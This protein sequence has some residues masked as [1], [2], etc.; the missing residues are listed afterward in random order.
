MSE[1]AMGPDGDVTQSVQ[2]DV[3]RYSVTRNAQ[4]KM[5]LDDGGACE[6]KR[7]VFRELADYCFDD[8][9]LTS[10]DDQKYVLLRVR[11]IANSGFL[12]KLCKR[13]E[14]S[15][16][17]LDHVALEVTAKTEE[18]YPFSRVI[19]TLE[20]QTILIEH[21][22]KAF[23]KSSTAAR[24]LESIARGFVG[25]PNYFIS[26]EEITETA[27]FWETVHGAERI[28]SVTFDL[29]SPN[30]LGSGYRTTEFLKMVNDAANNDSLK[31]ELRNGDGDLVIDRREFGD[32]VDYV[33]DGCGKWK[34]DVTLDGRNQ[35]VSSDKFVR[36]A[37]L[38]VPDEPSLDDERIMRRI[39]KL[40]RKR[41]GNNDEAGGG[42]AGA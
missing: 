33:T 30:F 4:V 42:A 27:K 9:E 16:Y 24:A 7:D 10:G 13:G 37:Y 5:R 35:S 18:S 40:G 34:M 8:H 1:G 15:T 25:D 32:A 21:S 31:V 3:Y 36:H 12:F 14:T 22:T 19:L 20:D 6:E 11:R 38:A 39:R 41:R 2:F 28:R 29:R 23:R 17:S 26:I